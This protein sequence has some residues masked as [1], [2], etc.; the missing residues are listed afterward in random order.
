MIIGSEIC[1]RRERK[2]NDVALVNFHRQYTVFLEESELNQVDVIPKNLTFSEK[3]LYFSLINLFKQYRED[4][5][6]DNED[7]NFDNLNFNIKLSSDYN[8]EK[9]ENQ[10]TDVVGQILSKE[11]VDNI[12]PTNPD[13]IENSHENDSLVNNLEKIAKLYE[14]GFLTND[15]FILM[16]Q[17]LFGKNK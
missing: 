16:K 11:Q 7:N 5:I 10:L 3:K 14:N 17:R 8:N 12:E 1:E 2:I 9:Y 6:L 15:E 13:F 4:L